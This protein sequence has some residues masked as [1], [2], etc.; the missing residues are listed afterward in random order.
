M[1]GE[2]TELPQD[3]I[4]TVINSFFDDKGLVNQQLSS[5]NEFME[6]TLVDVMEEH[7]TFTLDQTSQ[8]GTRALDAT[9]RFNIK[10]SHVFLGPP[11]TSENDGSVHRSTPQD[12]RLRNGTYDC[13]LYMTVS[14]KVEKFIP[15]TEDEES[16]W[17]PDADYNDVE[18]KQAYVGRIPIM[19][20]SNFC[21]THKMSAEQ[22]Q[23]IGECPMDMGGYFIINGSEKVLIAQERMA[24]NYVYVFE[25]AQPSNVSHVAELTSVLSTAGMS[26]M[27]KMVVKLFTA[28]GEKQQGNGTIRATLPYVKQDIPIFVIFRA[29][30]IL[31]DEDIL[32]LICYDLDDDAFTDM[33]KPSVEEASRIQTQDAALDYIGRRGNVGGSI[34]SE[35]INHALDILAKETLPHISIERSGFK[36]KAYFF[37]YMVHRLIMA[38]LNRREL[39]DRD[40]F[41]KKRLDLA[42]PLLANLF[43]QLYRK[44]TRDIY[45]N[46]QK[47][48]DQGR[49]FNI[50]AAINKNIITQGLR[51]SLATGNWQ[52]QSKAMEGKV[53][54]SQ[55]LNRYTYASTLSHLRRT[56]TPI[57]RDG[58]IAKPRQLHNTHWGMVCPAETPEGQ[59]CGLVKNLSL[60]SVISVGSP[61]GPILDYMKNL[62]LS[63]LDG[64]TAD[65]EATRVFLNGVWVGIST[66][67]ASLLDNLVTERR[68]GAIRD[69]VSIVREIRERELRVYTDAGRVM[70]PLF[71][72]DQESQQVLIKQ[73]DVDKLQNWRDWKDRP[74]D[75]E[76]ADE[77][78]EYVWQDLLR[79]GKVEYLD[80]EEEEFV[81][82]AMTIE[83]LL[84]APRRA[85]EAENPGLKHEVPA[86]LRDD[87]DPSMRIKSKSYSHTYT[88]CE[89]HPS[90]IL[91]VCATIVPFP[92][93]NQ[94]RRDI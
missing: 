44:F 19:V 84:D 87:F 78:P 38:K 42:G 60:M 3:S 73:R 62:G 1:A 75:A 40:H 6:T 7:G 71:V 17:E 93:H 76:D 50:V 52:E 2:S 64:Y 82:I 92:D 56:N 5:F 12:A 10:F 31:P 29:M 55:V 11:T 24:G 61:D 77:P 25:K 57:G 90:M 13:P 72:V 49:M 28:K 37:G 79:E 88:H 39:D 67:P 74:A 22:Q 65:P 81:M 15:P 8:G 66:N 9:R 83:D 70:R 69:E 80:A 58:K 30:G 48:S 26:K 86:E 34:R 89:I 4:W 46:L 32:K 23:E 68:Q 91:G 41:G 54:V 14:Q 51:Y 94:V 59:A 21:Y 16:R 43:R 20:R 27:S 45:R 47:C 53:G 36:Q 35:R 85:Y 18:V 33:L 63:N